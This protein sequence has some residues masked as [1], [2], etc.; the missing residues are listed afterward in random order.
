MT[1]EKLAQS[2][3][4]LFTQGD[5]KK[6]D[7]FRVPLDLL[8]VEDGFNLRAEGVELEAHIEAIAQFILEGGQL[9]PLEVRVLDGRVLIVEGHCRRRA[10]R[11][12]RERGAPV[13]DISVIPFKGND[14][15]RVVKMI[16]SSQG[17]ALT[18]LETALGYKRL[19]AFG[20]AAEQIGKKVGKTRQHVEQL[21]IL[22]NANSD[23]HAMVSKGV[24][25]AAIAIDAVRKHG[26]KAGEFLIAQHDKAKAAGK[27]KVTAKTIHGKALP[28]QVVTTVVSALDEFSEAIPKNALLLLASLESAEQSG[29]LPDG[30]EVSVPASA[31]LSLLKARKAVTE[32]RAAQETKARQK[33]EKAAQTELKEEA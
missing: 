10:Y 24:V 20:M 22:A 5:I 2:L 9:P 17:K 29:A 15:D 28:R 4:G 11:I 16:A 33:A 31:L 21:L 1:Q 7:S 12:A 26:E 18:P 6:T 8:E 30:Q 25:S 14:A 32:E 23:V 13:E 3:K 27:S 19:E